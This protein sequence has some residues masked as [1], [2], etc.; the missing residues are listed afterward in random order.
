[1]EA[2]VKTVVPPGPLNLGAIGVRPTPYSSRRLTRS[3]LSSKVVVQTKRG[4]DTVYYVSIFASVEGLRISPTRQ[5]L[6]AGARR[7]TTYWMS[8]DTREL[9]ERL[10]STTVLVIMLRQECIRRLLSEGTTRVPVVCLLFGEA[11]FLHARVDRKS[12]AVF[13]M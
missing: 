3:A 5:R 13:R 2:R 8:V 7:T 12:L 6:S 4:V 1:M 11:F 10:I 9:L